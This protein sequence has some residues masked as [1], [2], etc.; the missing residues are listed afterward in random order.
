VVTVIYRPLY[1]QGRKSSSYL[2]D[3]RFEGPRAGLYTFRKEKK[4]LGLAGNGTTIP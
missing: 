2:F 4:C 1:H 3:R